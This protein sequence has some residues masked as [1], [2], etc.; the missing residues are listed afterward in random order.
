MV[1]KG[2][3]KAPSRSL[4]R[5]TG[6]S[7]EDMP[8][9]FIGIANSYNDIVPGHIHLNRLVEEIKHG[10]IESGGVPFVFGVPG[11]CDGIA[12]GHA[13]M[14]FSLPSR[15]TIADCIE[16]MDNA[17]C[18]DGWVGVTNCDKITPGML[19]AAGRI[20]IPGIVLT[21]GPMMEGRL[22]GQG[23]DLQSVFEALGAYTAGDM[24]E[25][26]VIRVESSACPGRIRAR[27]FSRPIRWHA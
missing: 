16:I 5:A 17:H 14:R 2:V 10:I 24:S 22:D 26:E 11:V 23:K 21:G 3:E 6:V 18:F 4:L 15:E 19:M 27:A 25:E 13:G 20:D 7:Y 9:P 8:K 12:M 1:K